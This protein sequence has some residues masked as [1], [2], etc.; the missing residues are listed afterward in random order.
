MSRD[1]QTIFNMALDGDYYRCLH[2]GMCPALRRMY[3]KGLITPMEYSNTK[4]SIEDYVGRFLY[5]KEKLEF[6]ELPHDQEAC[7]AIYRNWDNRP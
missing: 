4:W 2:E 3:S 5:L 7:I 1:I 6:N